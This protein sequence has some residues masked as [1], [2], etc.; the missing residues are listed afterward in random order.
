MIS[1]IPRFQLENTPTP[2]W[3]GVCNGETWWGTNHKSP[4][5]TLL[6]GV[7][8]YVHDVEMRHQLYDD[9]KGGIYNSRTRLSNQLLAAVHV[10]FVRNRC[11]PKYVQAF[12]F[13]PPACDGWHRTSGVETS[14]GQTDDEQ[15]TTHWDVK[16]G[17]EL[18]AKW[19]KRAA[20]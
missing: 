11:F 7:P 2:P 12:P 16:A 17:D 9:Q 8:T 14:L 3:R 1:W 6:S 5:F 13:A 4:P 10:I 20:V 19:Q 15:G 18:G